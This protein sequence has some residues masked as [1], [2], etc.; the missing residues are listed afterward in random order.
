MP[1]SKLMHVLKRSSTRMLFVQ[2]L[3]QQISGLWVFL[4]GWSIAVINPKMHYKML[5]AKTLPGKVNYF[6]YVELNTHDWM[7]ISLKW[8]AVCKD[9][10]LVA[11]LH[12]EETCG[13]KL[14][15]LLEYLTGFMFCVQENASGFLVSCW[16]EAS[17]PNF[18]RKPSFS[19]CGLS[20]WAL[21]QAVIFEDI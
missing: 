18:S 13:W 9:D 17:D 16:L 12:E 11:Y 7:K 4:D 15:L 14:Y 2:V 10:S 8:V 5:Y 20:C 3:R 19:E 6:K 21:H 1:F